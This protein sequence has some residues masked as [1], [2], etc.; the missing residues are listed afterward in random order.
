MSFDRRWCLLPFPK[1]SSPLTQVHVA[2]LIDYE[3]IYDKDA[4]EVKGRQFWAI[5]SLLGI[6]FFQIDNTSGADG[7]L[8]PCYTLF[9][10]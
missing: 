9:T 8:T 1:Q 7:V 10:T 5:G 4:I 6:F 2:K 3:S